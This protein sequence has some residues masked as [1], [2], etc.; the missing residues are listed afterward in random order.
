MSAFSI[1]DLIFLPPCN[2]TLTLQMF[3]KNRCRPMFAKSYLAEAFISFVVV[4]ALY[5]SGIVF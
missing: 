3:R 5:K 4:T 2:L 1:F